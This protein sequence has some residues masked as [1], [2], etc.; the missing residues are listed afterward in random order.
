M[1]AA[2]GQLLPIAAALALSS[3]PIVCVLTLLL[4]NPRRSAP[5][6]FAI[7]Y[8]CGMAALML[9]ASALPLSTGYRS[10]PSGGRIGWIEIAV[11]VACLAL[12]AIAVWRGG[13]SGRLGTSVH[14]FSGWLTRVG[15]VTGL[16]V[17]I[18]VNI[19]PKS[20]LLIGAAG[21]IIASADVQFGQSTMLALGVVV[22]GASTVSGP[23]AVAFVGRDHASAWLEAASRWIMNNG[24]TVT[25]VVLVLIGVMVLGAGLGRT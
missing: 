8:T 5:V 21:L 14:R 25:V 3:V 6:L 12:A 16:L 22:I 10:P 2:I 4:Q 17:G 20:M 18:L 24:H 1:L 9:C 11:G 7:G 13:D 23:V 19:R 15:P